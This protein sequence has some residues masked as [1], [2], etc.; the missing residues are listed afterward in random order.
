[1]TVVLS[2]HT[3]TINSNYNIG[4]YC[5]LM[6]LQSKKEDIY[7]FGNNM[8]SVTTHIYKSTVEWVDEKNKRA[9]HN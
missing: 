3:C 6:L 1:M 4:W 5:N 2:K 8:T 7:R 9:V